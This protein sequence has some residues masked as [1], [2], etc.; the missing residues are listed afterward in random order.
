MAPPDSRLTRLVSPVLAARAE[1]LEL[2]GRVVGCPPAV[3]MVEGEAGVG[4]TRL[5][6]ELSAG[7]VAG[8][9]RVLTGNCHPMPEPFPLGPVV[10]AVR[11]LG[12]ELAALPLTP[13]A[14]ALRPLL[15]ELADRLP[16][17]PEPLGDRTMER[18][19]L[20]RALVELLHAAGPL[21]VVLEDLHWSDDATPQFLA[22]LTAQ[23]PP[24]LTLVLT[25]RVEELAGPAPLRSL[26]GRLPASTSVVRMQLHPL[27][28]EDVKVV[29]GAILETDCV[30]D[31]FAAY[32]HERTAGIPLAVEEVLR[33]LVDRRDIVRWR[34]R[35]ARR[36]LE[37]VEVPAAI[38]DAV[39]E[40]AG[41]LTTDA[42]RIVE[43]AA[44]VGEPAPEALLGAVASLAVGRAAAGLADAVAAGVLQPAGEGYAC[45]HALAA[46]AVY[47]AITEPERRR[48]HQRAAQTLEAGAEGTQGFGPRLPARLAHHWKEA[49]RSGSWVRWAEQ[50]AS[51][52]S[53]LGDPGAAAVLL[54][55]AVGATGLDA[56]TRGG[57]ALDLA[58]AAIAS[59]AQ[60]EAIDA[61][62]HVLGTEDLPPSLRGDLRTHLGALLH[63][64]GDASAANAQFA[65]SVPDLQD[66]P[67]LLA[68][69]MVA[70]ALPWVA[71]NDLEHHLSWLGRAVELADDLPHG[72]LR[73]MIQGD[74][75]AILV[76]VGD[77]AGWAA[78]PPA[79]APETSLGDLQDRARLCTNLAINVFYLGH[80]TRAAAFA[81]E[82]LGI[83]EDTG[84]PRMYPALR[85]AEVLLD[86]A[87]G[88][89]DGLGKA[90]QEVVDS[91]PDVPSLVQVN[92]VLGHVALAR[93]E[94]DEA[95]EVLA[96]VARR[97]R[98]CG[99]LPVLGIAAAALARARLAD[100][101]PPGA[102]AH[103]LAALEVLSVKGIWCW[104][105]GV[106]PTAVTALVARGS[107][108]EAEDWYRRLAAG[109]RGRDAPGAHAA[110]LACRAVVSEAGSHY[111]QAAAHFAR[112]AGAW[113]R[114]GRPYEEALAAE[115]QARCLLITE[116]EA[117]TAAGAE[118]LAI[119]HRLGAAWDVARVR[120]L[121]RRH[122]VAVPYP[123]TGGRRSYGDDLSPREQEVVRLAADGLTS[124]RIAARL[125]LSPR[126]VDNHLARAMRKLGISS[127]KELVSARDADRRRD[128]NK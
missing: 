57:L 79:P 109:V 8:G 121:L 15:P 119:L 122:E 52:A 106:L 43:A 77:Q 31:E 67:D 107:I 91:Q 34:G 80:D 37:Q 46:Q 70:L 10:E 99:A 40:R 100:D 36:A 123:R 72:G 88:R 24:E 93:G 39:L 27:A 60:A 51:L 92:M 3:A 50:A 102:C 45:R 81:A 28:P 44:V 18:H 87:G 105:A 30:S 6:Q 127:R 94:V 90:A 86:W 69:V 1:E 110:L 61:V 108:S 73:T 42:R 71:E 124:S 32:L 83:S 53:A 4:K 74:R 96:D 103:V 38:R 101:D 97:A 78:V 84:Y 17:A 89:W 56:E 59:L 5:V 62:R 25:S 66:S 65:L 22:F 63:Q 126:T 116:S 118:A 75:A 128:Q 12:D 7:L 58:K 117:G 68:Q 112:A 29:I 21:V 23:Q 26:S 111:S 55:D 49:G 35:W 104:T 13:L 41:A 11:A 82:G 14:G 19:R 85:T 20:W 16:P 47:G 114:L 113:S 54:L 120:R 33:L 76:A 64:A 95:E 48:M 9:R 98:R 115:G 2:L 125:F